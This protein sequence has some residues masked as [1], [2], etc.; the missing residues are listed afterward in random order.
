MVK[1]N[2]KKVVSRSEAIAVIRA[3]IADCATPI[4]IADLSNSIII[5]D[6]RFDESVTHA[7]GERFPILLHDEPIGWVIGENKA[8]EVAE[9]LAFLALKEMEQKNLAA[10]ALEKYREINLL[11]GFTEKMATCLDAGEVA[12]LVLEE[13]GRLI[14]SSSA[15]VMLYNEQKDVLEVTYGTGAM[16]TSRLTLKPNEG[17]AGNIFVSGKPEVINNVS[18]DPR[19]YPHTTACFSMICAPLQVKDRT[20]G[21]IN[22]STDEKVSYTSQDLKLF[23]VLTSQ[24]ASAIEN[25]L[26][27]EH[28]L[29][30]MQIR[31]NLGRYLSPQVVDA[32]INAE[33]EISLTTSMR[34]VTTLFSDIRSFTT[35]CEELDAESIVSYLNSY[36][37]NLV[38]VIFSHQGTVNKFVGDMIVAM[39]GAPADLENQELCAVRAAIGMQRCLQSLPDQW[40]RENFVTGIGISS[41]ESVVGNIGSS[42]HMDYTAIGDEVNVASRLQ[43][44]AQGGQILVSRSV[45]DAV[46]LQSKGEFSFQAYGTVQVKGKK[47]AVEVFEVIY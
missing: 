44:L 17:I 45:Y 14:P 18:R 5:H 42:Q 22:I 7:D 36:F 8:P 11:Y 2:L 20:I 35:K 6:L 38:A 29:K 24:A 4:T 16:A 37:S 19:Y 39:F 1:V 23:S 3:L 41:G 32:V 43:G 30:Q 40:I 10:D 28:R 25:A 15:S 13:A 21:V 26:L 47:N 12:T 33:E 34:K 9:F 31:N 46:A 27:H